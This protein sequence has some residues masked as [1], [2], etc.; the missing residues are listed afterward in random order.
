MIGYTSFELNILNLLRSKAQDQGLEKGNVRPHEL[1]LYSAL[2][3]TEA[4]IRFNVDKKTNSGVNPLSLGLDERDA[5]VATR[6][7]L[8][9]HPTSFVSSVEY[10]A[11]TP[12]FFHP[13]PNYFTGTNEA[14][15]LEVIYNA[16]MNINSNQ[17]IRL[18][19]LKTRNFRVVQ[20]TQRIAN[21]YTTDGTL[22]SVF[23]T[24]PMQNGIEYKPLKNAIAFA[25]GDTS[26]INVTWKQGL[27]SGIA[28]VADTRTNFA[29]VLLQGFII[30]NGVQKL[31]ATEFNEFVNQ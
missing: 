7:A 18:Q 31:T 28:G 2:S 4:N 11:N 29:V 6:L 15:S 30:K 5:F 9:I 21:Y 22:D 10:Y 24:A 13:D 12:I 23:S 8:G 27:Y 19:D 16:L 17:E 26:E 1:H 3:A 25:G 20:Q 14:A